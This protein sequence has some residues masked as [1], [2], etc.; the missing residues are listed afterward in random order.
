M[1][2]SKIDIIITAQDEASKALQAITQQTQRLQNS[3]DAMG[4][5]NTRAGVQVEG[6][7]GSLL[8]SNLAS[9]ALGAAVNLTTDA[10]GALFRMSENA[11]KSA[12]DY[13]QLRISF[14]SM[15][16]SA[17]QART[18]LKQVSDF[19]A[20]TPFTLPQVAEGSRQLLAYGTA[21]KDVIPCG[22]R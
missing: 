1:A 20:S 8:R 10:L 13:E 14:E 22:M 3:V 12:A 7:T 11:V 6:L 16:G 15:L 17:D 9:M 4:S 18:L 19:A 5:S 21:A 2:D